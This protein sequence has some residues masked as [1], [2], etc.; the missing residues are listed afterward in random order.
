MPL[1]PVGGGIPG[2]PAALPGY[3]GAFASDYGRFA[4]LSDL[5]RRIALDEREHK[6]RSLARMDAPRFGIDDAPEPAAPEK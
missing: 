5:F 6:E 2:A 1:F 4:T 3:D